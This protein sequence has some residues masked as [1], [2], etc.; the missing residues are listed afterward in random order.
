MIAPS[1]LRQLGAGV[2]L[3]AAGQ[4][5]AA[6]E[7]GDFTLIE[8][9]AGIITSKGFYPHTVPEVLDGVARL[10]EPAA[11]SAA[12]ED[13]IA[14][15]SE[16]EAWSAFKDRL[17]LLAAEPGQR[18]S[19]G[20]LIESGLRGYCLGIDPWTKY[21]TV[22]DYAR[23]KRSRSSGGGTIGVNLR[24]VGDG[25]IYLYPLPGSPA[26]FAGIVAGDR[27]LSVDGQKLEGKPIELIAS[28]ITGPPGTPTTLRV[29]RRNGRS[30]YVRV[31]REELPSAPIQVEKDLGGVTLRIR[32]FDKD[33]AAKLAE[34]L[35]TAGSARSLT[36]DLRGCIG[37]SLL[38]AIESA[39]L[40]LPAGKR[41]VSLAERGYPMQHFDSKNE[42]LPL[43]RNISILQDQGTA[44]AAELF[45]AALVENLP[46]Q[47]ATAGEPSYGKGV[48]Q[49]EQELAGGGKLNL[50]TGML[51]GP[52][53]LSWN[54]VGLLPS[55]ANEGRIFPAEAVS[56]S[57]PTTKPKAAVRLVE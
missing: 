33:L 23:I 53:G 34:H 3:A 25:E 26:G 45:I 7:S 39:D 46:R 36:I 35:K 41:I 57:N 9:A 2:L 28:W 37:G 12:V 50:T 17:S 19:L 20:E 56:I 18:R 54:G 6:Q 27:L 22:A 32:F 24:E 4:F 13:S 1:T 38:S 43:P 8:E 21:Y 49:L 48:V 10:A 47:V 55:V 40:F 44:S 15:L 31:N 5:A 16:P 42:P 11:A 52:N 51:F 30:E 29:E 14:A